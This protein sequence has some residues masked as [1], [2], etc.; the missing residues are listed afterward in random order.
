MGSHTFSHFPWQGGGST[1]GQ[2]ASNKE[3]TRG[4][5][6][7]SGAHDLHGCARRAGRCSEGLGYIGLLLPR[8]HMCCQTVAWAPLSWPAPATYVAALPMA[9]TGDVSSVWSEVSSTMTSMSS[10]LERRAR[11]QVFDPAWQELC[12]ECV[13][14][15][16]APSPSHTQ[17]TRL[18]CDRD[19]RGY[20]GETG[21]LRSEQYYK[22]RLKCWHQIQNFNWK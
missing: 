5:C 8:P 6:G 13:P 18:G 4:R 17:P 14:Q 9:R 15:T 16:P 10:S 20:S 1:R 21:T 3:M 2:L 22:K 11:A 19:G 7:H 12:G